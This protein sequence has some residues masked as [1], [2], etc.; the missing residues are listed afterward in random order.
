M[1]KSLESLH[2]KNISLETENVDLELK[3]FNLQK[4][5]QEALDKIQT[6]SVNSTSNTTENNINILRGWEVINSQ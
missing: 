6:L 3:Y 2:K 1:K 4:N 5:Y